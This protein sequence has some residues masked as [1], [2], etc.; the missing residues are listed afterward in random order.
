MT[1]E[2]TAEFLLELVNQ[3]FHADRLI[4]EQADRIE[5]LEAELDR[6]RAAHDGNGVAA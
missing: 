6:L 4:S 5:A 2:A 3:L 1:T